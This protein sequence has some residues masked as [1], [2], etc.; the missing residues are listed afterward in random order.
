M[1][2]P[3]ASRAAT[4]RVTAAAAAAAQRTKVKRLIWAGSFAAITIVGTIYGAGLKSQ[5]EYK[6][7]VKNYVHAG[8]E[9][10]IAI[11]ERRKQALMSQKAP[12]EEKLEAL[13]ERMAENKAKDEERRERRLVA[14]G[15]NHP[16]PSLSPA[17]AA[18]NPARPDSSNKG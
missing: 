5:Q 3:V 6:S 13:R 4:A 8:V 1:A 11:L 17:T 14:S 16:Q 12:L 10:Q 18:P 9:E 7:E 15:E 2:G